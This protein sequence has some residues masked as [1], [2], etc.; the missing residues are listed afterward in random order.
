MVKKFSLNQRKRVLHIATALSWRG[1]EQQLAYLVT[2]LQAEVDQIVLCSQGSEMEKFCQ[3]N[4]IDYEVQSKRGGFDLA[5]ALKIKSLCKKL[6]IDLC[7][8]HDAHAHTFAILAAVLGNPTPLVLSRRVD[9]PIKKKWT[10]KFKY[11]HPAIKKILC[12]SEMIK[13]ITAADIQDRGKLHTVYSGI[14]L[15]KFSKRSGK[16]RKELNIKESTPL[17]GNTSALADHKDYFTFLDTAETVVKQRSEV[18]FVIMGDGPMAD[19]IKA[20]ARKKKLDNNLTFTGYRN[21][22]SEV[23]ADLDVFLITS[24]TEG[25][26]TSILDAFACQVLVVA[27]NAGGIPELVED[28]KTGLLCPVKEVGQLSTSVIKMLGDSELANKLRKSAFQKVQQFSKAETARKTL[29]HYQEV[30]S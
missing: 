13:K 5:Y 30:W 11:N 18:Q 20:Y 26:G 9:F 10:S 23:L 25:L 27:T 21:D 6:D 19:E 24:K 8:M 17:I 4:S 3:K 15:S 16:L 7:H 2:E 22:I 28:H 1:G 14:D 12:V 29:E